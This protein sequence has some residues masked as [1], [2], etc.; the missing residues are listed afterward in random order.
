MAENSVV[1]HGHSPSLF[2]QSPQN[3]SV[4]LQANHHTLISGHS[5]VNSWTHDL[6][7][8]TGNFKTDAQVPAKAKTKT[9]LSLSF[10]TV[11]LLDL[12]LIIRGWS[13]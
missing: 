2:S 9:R 10:P 8:L 7:W 1:P 6:S 12:N 3:I 13:C 4:G 11:F 5:D